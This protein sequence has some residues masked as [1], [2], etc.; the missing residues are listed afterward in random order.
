MY[1]D[2]V[3][4]MVLVDPTPDN[5]RLMMRQACRNS[6]PSPPRSI[7]HA[8]V[9]LRSVSLLFLIDAVSPPEVPF[10]TEG[11]RTLRMSNRGEL[12][13]ESLEHRRWLDTIPGS[14]LIVTN[15]SG[16]NVAQEQPELVVATI[17][18]VVDEATA[19]SQR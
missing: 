18:Q 16:H 5:E 1:P 9:A 19:R 17:R 14:R 13:A 2:D 10:A 12:E 6:S 3:A 11:I 7:R 15:H 8:P 4:G